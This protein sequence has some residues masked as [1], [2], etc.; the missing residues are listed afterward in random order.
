MKKI[1]VLLTLLCFFLLHT[2]S[3]QTRKLSGTVTSAEDGKGIPGVTVLV[4]GTTNGVLTDVEGKYIINVSKDA[5][6]LQFTF[7]GMEKQEV[8]IG[9]SNV[10]DVSLAAIATTL[11]EILVLGKAGWQKYDEVMLN[12]VTYHCYRKPKRFGGLKNVQV[13]SK[14]NGLCT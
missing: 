8:P 13:T 7:I 5:T 3:A 9:V 4:K 12:G 1:Y 10:I 14:T 2:V 11:D 6:A